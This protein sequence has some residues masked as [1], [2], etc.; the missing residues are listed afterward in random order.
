MYPSSLSSHPWLFVGSPHYLIQHKAKE[1]RFHG[2]TFP[3]QSGGLGLEAEGVREDT[4]PRDQKEVR[5]VGAFP[6]LEGE[7]ALG[8]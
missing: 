2:V 6:V 7:W 3:A 8:R 5:V 1:K 4:Q